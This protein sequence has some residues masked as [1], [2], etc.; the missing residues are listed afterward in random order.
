[1][2]EDYNILLKTQNWV[3]HRESPIRHLI[4]DRLTTPPHPESSAQHAAD[5][6]NGTFPSVSCMRGTPACYRMHVSRIYLHI[7]RHRQRENKQ[8]TSCVA[9]GVHPSIPVAERLSS[10]L[11]RKMFEHMEIAGK[12][13]L[14]GVYVINW[15][16]ACATGTNSGSTMSAR[17]QEEDRMQEIC[18]C[19]VHQ[20]REGD[21]F[22]ETGFI[23]TR[24]MRFFDTLHTIQQEGCQTRHYHGRQTSNSG[25]SL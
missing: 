1:M 25:S 20:G 22:L 9:P 15:K 2:L 17:Q 3:S 11:Y 18:D 5:T 8:G 13:R 21:I 4:D 23:R 12:E 10:F 14:V 19:A 16:D 6:H 7:R 24:W